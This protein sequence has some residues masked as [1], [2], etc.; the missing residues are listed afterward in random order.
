MT[1][2]LSPAPDSPTPAPEQPKKKPAAKRAEYVVFEPTGE[3]DTWRII[4]NVSAKN[5]DDAIE[6]AV[7][8]KPE[9][10]QKGTYVAVASAR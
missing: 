4:D 7:A 10:E 3:V 1:E 2:P 5:P 9:D 8:A 6:I